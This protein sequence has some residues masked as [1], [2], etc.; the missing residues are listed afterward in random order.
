M[1]TVLL[2]EQMVA[3]QYR[4]Q[5]VVDQLTP[6]VQTSAT[7]LTA[8]TSGTLSTPGPAGDGTQ[9]L[10]LPQAL[11]P[12]SSPAFA[13]I[14]IG[15]GTTVKKIQAGSFAADPASIPATSTGT[16]DI[17]ITGLAVGDVVVL[18]RPNGLSDDL[19]YSGCR[20]QAANTLRIYLYNPTA[21]AID[22]GSLTWE[23]CWIDLT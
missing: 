16:V 6:Q 9:N 15:G 19:I 1:D 12:A 5:D 17:T 7:A 10:E 3:E 21:G 18:M 22:D 4:Q 23:Y 2:D 20:V 8:I 11:A 14:T 13:A